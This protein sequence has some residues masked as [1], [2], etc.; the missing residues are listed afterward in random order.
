MGT[1]VGVGDG[2]AV[3][4]GVGGGNSRH[5]SVGT[6]TAG[7]QVD[8]SPFDSTTRGVDRAGA[9]CPAGERRAAD[10][11]AAHAASASINAAAPMSRR[12]GRIIGIASTDNPDA[13]A[14]PFFYSEA[15]LD[16]TTK[17]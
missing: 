9:P 12:A 3:G 8:S 5:D 15:K 1:R 6:G 17:Q 7:G 10:H 4:D 2:V 16:T 14:L 13:I 11:L